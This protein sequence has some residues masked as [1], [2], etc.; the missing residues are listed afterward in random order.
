MLRYREPTGPGIRVD[1]GVAEGRDVSVYYDPLLAK[2]IVWGATRPEAIARTREALA[3]FEIL[4]VTTNLAFLAAL[5]AD[6]A[7]LAGRLDTGFID[8]ELA[9]LASP[10]TVPPEVIAAAAWHA[11]TAGP[12]ARSSGLAPASQF[13]PFDTI[14]GWRG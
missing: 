3:R 8:R 12:G 1:A 7:F 6:E 10:R 5:V 2:L 13:D 11:A 14:R 4:G 9:R